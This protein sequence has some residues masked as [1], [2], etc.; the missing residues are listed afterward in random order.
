MT[1]RPGRLLVISDSECLVLAPAVV[2]DAV[3]DHDGEEQQ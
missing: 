2:T 1:P 3:Q